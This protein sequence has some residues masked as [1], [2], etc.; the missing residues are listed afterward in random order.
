MHAAL[1]P[2]QPLLPLLPLLRLPLQTQK[3]AAQSSGDGEVSSYVRTVSLALLVLQNSGIFLLMRYTRMQPGP[4]CVRR[5]HEAPLTPDIVE[6]RR[7]RAS[8]LTAMALRER[9]AVGRDASRPPLPRLAAAA[10]AHAYTFQSSIGSHAP[11]VC[12]PPVLTGTWPQSLSSS[13]R[14]PSFCCA[15]PSS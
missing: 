1:A 3:H 5:R 11:H 12:A 6:T 7:P 14:S 9:G 4:K 8:A 15:R 2:Y 13:L 10:P